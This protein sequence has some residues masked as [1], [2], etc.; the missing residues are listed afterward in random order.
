M[1]EM[2]HNNNNNSTHNNHEGGKAPVYK[3]FMTFKPVEFKDYRSGKGQREF[4]EV[5]CGKY[6]TLSTR[7]KL[8][9]EFLE[10]KKGD[11]RIAD[12]VKRFERGKYFAP[13]ITRD[14]SMELN[15]FLEGLNA[16]IR[17][18]VRLSNPSSMRE[19]VDRALMAE[20]DRQNIIKEAQAKRIATSQHSQQ[21]RNFYH[22]NNNQRFSQ[23]PQQSQQSKRV[24][25][26]G[27]VFSA[28]SSNTPIPLCTICGKNHIRSCMQGSNACFLCKQR[29]NI[30]RDCPKK[31][32]VAPG[33][34]FSMT[35]E[36]ADPKTTIITG[37]LLIE[38]ILAN[39]LI[40][41]GATHSFITACF[42]QKAGL[43]PEESLM[44]YSISLPSGSH[45]NSNMIIKACPVYNQNHK[46]LVDL[47][48]VDMVGFD[49]ILCMDWLF[50]HEA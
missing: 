41:T 29:G 45:L 5:F 42:F 20:K 40:D 30:Q 24:Q 7:N 33:R 26:V 23:R 34:I 49:V 13:M 11:S 38:N 21:P 19:T 50:R 15:H 16:T 35:R 6:Y 32:E 27:S 43:K 48:V 36:E 28:K 47:M 22:N 4:K 39:T 9:R 46:M 18:N 17:W 2:F 8:A 1:R 37:N 44:A 25:L 10:I 12:Y 14:A 31:N 3:Q